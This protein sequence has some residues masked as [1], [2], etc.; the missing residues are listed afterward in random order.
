M[1]R[2]ERN[3]VDYFP[4]ECR[5]G[6]KMFVIESKYGNDGYAVWFKILECLGD[7]TY[8]YLDLRD[9]TQSMYLASIMRVSEEKFM[10]I[11]TDLA[12]LGAIDSIL[13]KDH[14][15][16][17]SAKLVESVQDAYSRRN[18][19]CIT[20]EGLREHLGINVVQKPS[21]SKPTVGKKPQSIEEYSKE[22]KSIYTNVSEFGNITI[23]K[24]K[25]EEFN[26]LFEKSKLDWIVKKLDSWLETKNKKCKGLKSF[27]AYCNNWVEQSY[28]SQNNVMPTNRKIVHPEPNK[29]P[30]P[31]ELI[32][33]RMTHVYK[34]SELV[35][36]GGDEAKKLFWYIEKKTP[37]E[38]MNQ[39]EKNFHLYY[40]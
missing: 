15:I 28:N 38:F 30:N 27:K 11:L 33:D 26:V 5:H 35:Q 23:E 36:M 24:E 7:A 18:N 9:A 17:W 12:T 19:K 14:K 32:K 20:F 34:D 10:Q 29:V 4:H 21:K 2:P 1:A 37:K 31:L 25:V 16:V 22:E 39:A 13:F 6:K 3:N 8:H 40:Y